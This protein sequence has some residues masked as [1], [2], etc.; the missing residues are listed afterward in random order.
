[1]RNIF[2]KFSELNIYSAAVP[3][4]MH[5][6]DLG[7]FNYQ[8][9]F[10]RNYIQL[11]CRKDGI[12]EF[13]KHLA[14]IPRFPELKIFK[15]GLGNIARFTAAEFRNMMKQLVF[16][17]DGLI[18]A[19]RKSNL[20]LFQAKQHDSKLVDLFVFWNRMYIFSRK[21]TFTDSELDNF[22]K[23]IID[24]ANKFI[25]LFT[26]IADTEMKYPKLHNWQH[27]IIDAIR[28]YGT[29][30]GFTTETYESL[31]KF[32]IKAPY[33]MSNRRD[34]TSQIINL[35]HRQIK[36]LGG[37]EGSFTLDTFNDFVD[38]YRTTHFLALE[39][40]KAFEVLIDSLNQYFDLIENITDKDVEATIIK[41]YT[42]AFIREV[43]TIRAK[44]NY[45]NAPAFSDI[46]INMNE[47]EA[48][49]YNTIDGIL[50]LFGLKIPGHNEQEL[51]LVHWYDFK[52]N[53]LHRLFKYDCPYVK[54]IP[55]FTVIAIESI[56]EPVHIIPCFNKTNE[57]FVNYFI[58]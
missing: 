18:V 44:S 23:M 32:Y 5:H 12:N 3:D 17:I 37:I 46:A 8:V 4:R 29:I 34:A 9:N 47:E 7:L 10:A 31:H 56:I 53:D 57:Y 28:N 20:S 39:A 14:K 21:D 36:T 45:Y 27:H 58:F 54:H 41:W 55:M 52:Y 30:N 38:E 16:V 25:N 33:R 15:S 40:E 42:S 26:P 48:E 6:C 51:A 22:Q 13:D 19:K 2:W 35:K 43:D 50:M 1:M 49:K 24:W 11:Y